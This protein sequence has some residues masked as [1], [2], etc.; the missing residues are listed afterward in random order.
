MTEPQENLFSTLKQG[1]I[2]PGVEES[3]WVWSL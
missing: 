3:H 2:L 1:F